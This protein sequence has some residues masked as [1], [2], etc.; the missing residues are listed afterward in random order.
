MCT[1]FKV[2]IESVT[3]LL[4]FYVL[5][6]WPWGTWDLSSPTRDRT[7]TPCSGRLSLNHW[8]TREVPSYFLVS[9]FWGGLFCLFATLHILWDL[10]SPN[11]DWTQAVNVQSPNHWTGREFPV[12]LILDSI[13]IFSFFLPSMLSVSF[14][15]FP[16]LFATSKVIDEKNTHLKITPF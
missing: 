13:K 8:T 16:I 6:F 3:V 7:C 12:S 11:R 1:I 2:F 14:F 15:V 10:R 4:L 9:I 5:V